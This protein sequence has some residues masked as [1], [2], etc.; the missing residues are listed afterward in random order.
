MESPETPSAVHHTI[1]FSARGPLGDADAVRALAALGVRLGDVGRADATRPVASGRWL[2][3]GLRS[4]G[5]V[6]LWAADSGGGRLVRLLE[7]A[8][9]PCAIADCLAD[10]PPEE[11]R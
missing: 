11:R 10:Q 4:D 7:A 6:E 3:C 8:G 9:M 5:L 2:A 1:I